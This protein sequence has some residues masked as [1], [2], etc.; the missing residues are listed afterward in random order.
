VTPNET[1]VIDEATLETGDETAGGG[2][3]HDFRGSGFVRLKLQ[4]GGT[5]PAT[6]LR[7]WVTGRDA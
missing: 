3:G 5:S 2:G 1:P 6:H 4:L 7:V